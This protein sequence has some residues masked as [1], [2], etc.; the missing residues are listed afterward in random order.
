LVFVFFASVP[1]FWLFSLVTSIISEGWRFLTNIRE[2][3][4]TTG[5]RWY[6]AL[7]RFLRVVERRCAHGVVHERNYGLAEEK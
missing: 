7:L 5:L 6:V 3:R 1:I 4:I 2:G